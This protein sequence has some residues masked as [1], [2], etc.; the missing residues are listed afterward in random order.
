VGP[1][2]QPLLP[3]VGVAQPIPCRLNASR[4]AVMCGV[5]SFT[6]PL[7]S[8]AASHCMNP[9]VAP[10]PLDDEPQVHACHNPM[11]PLPW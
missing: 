6:L 8:S 1:P 10:Q 5:P 7:S 3:A 9:L 2:P 4:S 11:L